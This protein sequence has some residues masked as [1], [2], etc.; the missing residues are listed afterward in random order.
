MSR[1]R[2]ILLVIAA[3]SQHLRA[4]L[5]EILERDAGAERDRDFA[6]L[7]RCGT[8][9]WIG[10]VIV[11]AILLGVVLIAW[12]LWGV[13]AFAQVPNPPLR[14]LLTE[15]TRFYL[16]D[17]QRIVLPACAEADLCPP[18]G[19]QHTVYDPTPRVIPISAS[20]AERPIFRDGFEP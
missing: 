15:P 3:W 11:V 16:P 1:L 10:A 19:A 9:L 4:M 17:G 6:H 8:D 18:L 20:C 12:G 7:H 14:V 13:P 2:A 5:F